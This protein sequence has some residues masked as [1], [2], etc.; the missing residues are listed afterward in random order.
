MKSE[1]VLFE[2]LND[3]NNIKMEPDKQKEIWNNI[4]KEANRN[5]QATIKRKYR[6]R[7]WKYSGGIGF[8]V[9]V[10][11]AFILISQSTNHTVNTPTSPTAPMSKLPSSGSIMKGTINE[12][13]RSGLAK[14]PPQIS[15]TIASIHPGNP[16]YVILKDYEEITK[17]RKRIQ[18]S[19]EK[20]ELP[21][22]K[23]VSPV[24]WQ[25]NGGTLDL[26]I[27]DGFKKMIDTGE[28]HDIHVYPSNEQFAGIVKSISKSKMIIQKVLYDTASNDS[29]AMILT[30]DT[31]TIHL[32][33]YTRVFLDGGGE[34]HPTSSIHQGDALSFILIGPPNE[35]IATEISDYKTTAK[36]FWNIK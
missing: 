4:L 3:L 29:H 34:E 13:Q 11:M 18:K 35:W 33:P 31:I 28:I 17:D 1:R 25:S 27:G 2:Q 8:V 19:E 21:A 9:A 20:V 32:A 16:S 23:M 15:G 26:F 24:H 22:G 30:N 14:I 6:K 7:I 5:G 36:A 12:G 10:V